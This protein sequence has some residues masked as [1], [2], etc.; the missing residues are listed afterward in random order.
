MGS[1]NEF[2]REWTIW[3][4]TLERTGPEND[5]VSPAMELLKPLDHQFYGSWKMMEVN[6]GLPK[7]LGYPGKSER[8]G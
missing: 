7:W 2:K 5:Q 6:D 8:V 3:P 1:W 4:S